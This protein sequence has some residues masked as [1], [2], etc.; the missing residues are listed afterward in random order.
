[1]LCQ[2]LAMRDHNRTKTV[3]LVGSPVTVRV[4]VVPVLAL[5]MLEEPTPVLPTNTQYSLTLTPVDQFSVTDEPT[6][7]VPWVGDVMTARN[8][9]V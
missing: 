4:R 1:M 8:P 9:P 6:M 7:G 3:P 5:R 2:V